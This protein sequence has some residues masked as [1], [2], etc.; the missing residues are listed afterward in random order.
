MADYYQTLGL[1]KNASADEIK[2]AFRKAALQHHPDK[3]KGEA[4]K[5]TAEAKFKEINEAYDVLKDPQKKAAYDQYGHEA[6]TQGARSGGFS[7]GNPFGGGSGAGG[8]G[9]PFGNGSGGYSF[10]FGQGGAGFGGEDIF[11]MFFGGG[12]RRQPRQ[13]SNAGRDLHYSVTISFDTAVHGG[14]EHIQ[15]NHLGT[16]PTCKGS[17]SK[18]NAKPI[19]C[20]R[21]G[22]SG[23]IAQTSQSI[24]GQFST[25][26]TCPKCGGEGKIIPDP[27]PTCAGKGR[28]TQT[29]DLTIQIPAGVDNGTEMRFAGRGDAGVRGGRAG[30]LYLEF[31][32]QPHKFFQRRGNNIHLTVPLNLS[33]AT[34]GTTIEV[35][36]I[37]GVTKVKIPAGIAPGTE[38][39]LSG[40]G[41]PRLNTHSRGDQILQIL[42]AVP[43]KLSNEEK[44]ILEQL[45]KVEPEP[46]KPWS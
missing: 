37:D 6:F 11:N 24:F 30:D 31:R 16:C 42:L 14:E 25:V 38:V 33:Q 36:T 23:E 13:A 19:T 40:K 32:V 15:L 43:N 20:D 2:K 27:C 10:D 9:N 46:K 28:T 1:N 4:A 29:E 41:V 8:Q 21:C 34:L 18:D 12:G 45:Q 39:K 44:K 5:K 35:P 17:G 26:T 22:G 3:A 7:G